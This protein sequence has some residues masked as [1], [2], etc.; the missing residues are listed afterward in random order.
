MEEF[1][2]RERDAR[3]PQHGVATDRDCNASPD[4]LNR[5]V[6]NADRADRQDK[7]KIAGVGF[8]LATEIPTS[9]QCRLALAVVAVLFAVFA[10][11]R[12]IRANVSARAHTG[13]D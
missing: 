4:F 13:T 12:G 7:S 9:G 5:S 6:K 8:A 3:D 1:R 11:E 2:L 10:A